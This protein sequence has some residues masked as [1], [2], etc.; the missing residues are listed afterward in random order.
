MNCA[1]CDNEIEGKYSQIT[2]EPLFPMGRFV[3][4]GLRLLKKGDCVCDEC[5]IARK[6]LKEAT[7]G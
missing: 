4:G 7:N 3:N 1:Y 6:P 5:L 2:K